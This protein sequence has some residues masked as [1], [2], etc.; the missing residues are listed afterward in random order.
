MATFQL[1][2]P[3]CSEVIESEGVDTVKDH[4]TTHLE[5]QHDTALTSVFAETHDG[6]ECHNCGSSFTVGDD[7][8]EGFEC[9]ECGHD[10][11]QPLVR[12]YLYWQIET[13]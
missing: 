11:F 9:S 5:N 13:E 8:I 2:C 4:G 3:F 1:D 6:D 10:H 12:R 7:G